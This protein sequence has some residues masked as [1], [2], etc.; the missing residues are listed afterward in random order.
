MPARVKY[1]SVEHFWFKG[2]KMITEK[3]YEENLFEVLWYYVAPD[4][5]GEEITEKFRANKRAIESLDGTVAP[6]EEQLKSIDER[7]FQ[8]WQSMRFKKQIVLCKHKLMI[9]LLKRIDPQ[10]TDQQA[11]EWIIQNM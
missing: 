5:T 8:E 3:F 10:M 7:A 9:A 6:T 1:G 11:I 4:A 2:L